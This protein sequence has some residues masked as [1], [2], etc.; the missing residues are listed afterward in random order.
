MGCATTSLITNFKE[1]SNLKPFAVPMLIS[2][3][4]SKNTTDCFFFF[5]CTNC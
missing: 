5:C 2:L 1:I 4:H 3:K